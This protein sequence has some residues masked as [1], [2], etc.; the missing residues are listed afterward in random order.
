MCES[1]SREEL[2]VKDSQGKVLEPSLCLYTSSDGRLATSRGILFYL[3]TIRRVF[4][5]HGN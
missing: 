3:Q 4:S 1:R 2:T 5:L